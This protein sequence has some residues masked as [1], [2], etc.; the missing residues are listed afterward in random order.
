M[1]AA[2]IVLLCYTLIREAIFQYTTQKLINKLMSRDFVSYQYG[3]KANWEAKKAE[4]KTEEAEPSVD[5]GVL[6]DYAGI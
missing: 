2:F 4:P 6:S 5:I 1:T 3:Q